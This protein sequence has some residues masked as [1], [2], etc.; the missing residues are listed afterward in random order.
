MSGATM[1]PEQERLLAKA[2]ATTKPYHETDLGNARRLVDL[3]GD[4]IRFRYERTGGRWHAWDGRS[5]ALD[6]RGEVERCAQGTVS[7]ILGESALLE[8]DERIKRAKWALASEGLSRLEAMVKAAR[9]DKRIVVTLE[10]FDHDPWSLNVANGIVD[11]KTGELRDHDPAEMHS[12]ITRASL[13]DR[14]WMEAAPEWRRFIEQVLPD[15]DVRDYVQALVGYTAAGDV[16]ENVLPFPYGSGANGKSVFLGALRHVLGDYATEAAPDLLVARRERGIPTDVADLRGYR[17]VTTTEVEGGNR[18]A[19]DL[20][21]RIT[22]DDTLKARRMRQDFEEFRNVTTIWMAGNDRPQV[23]GLDPAIWR[24]MHLI[25]FNVVI[26][27]GQRDPDLPAKLRAEQNGILSWLV[28]GSVR[29]HAAKAKGRSA[30]KRPQAVQAATDEYREESNPLAAWFESKCEHRE[31]AKESARA[32][33]ESYEQWTAVNRERRVPNGRKW[34]DGLMA[35]GCEQ[36][37]TDG[38][39]S[40][41]GKQV[42]AWQGVRLRRSWSSDQGGMDL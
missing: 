9:S 31:G 1:T 27:E 6:Q 19:T 7:A 2:K 16:G 5:W 14:P 13:P 35:L 25:P 21:K 20:M 11:L 42:R 23:D 18:M 22:G 36:P 24:R 26:P 15:R 41:D 4:R 33:R 28:E 37:G 3:Y 30:I 17:L 34:A 40:I 32:L 38:R 12:K 39:A 10:D 29:Y 8:G